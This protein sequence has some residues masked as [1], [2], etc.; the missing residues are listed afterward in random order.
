MPHFVSDARVIELDSNKWRNFSLLLEELKQTGQFNGGILKFKLLPEVFSE[1]EGIFT[2]LGDV[3]GNSFFRGFSQLPLEQYLTQKITPIPGI[4]EPVYDVDLS[5]VVP[6]E[7]SSLKT[8][9]DFY[10][11]ALEQRPFGFYGGGV[12]QQ[13]P[14]DE[15]DSSTVESLTS[16]FWSAC[17]NGRMNKDPLLYAADIYPPPPGTVEGLRP[18]LVSFYV[19]QIRFLTCL[20]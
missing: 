5:A 2:S 12:R 10:N 4:K 8:V 17:R 19:T 20:Q 7:E 15:F 6:D 18:S 14:D 3:G 11:F 13:P 1:F 9:G 16:S